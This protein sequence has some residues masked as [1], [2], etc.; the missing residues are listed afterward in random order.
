[1]AP[2]PFDFGDEEDEKLPFAP[3]KGEPR[4]GGLINRAVPVKGET[5]DWAIVDGGN[6]VVHYMT[7]AARERL[8]IE[9]LWERIAQGEADLEGS[10][11]RPREDDEYDEADQEEEPQPVAPESQVQSDAIQDKAATAEKTI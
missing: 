8:D 1:M 4:V 9:G 6:V 10:D 7:Q 11:L 2:R 3:P 5:T